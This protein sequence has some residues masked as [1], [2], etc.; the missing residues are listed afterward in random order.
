MDAARALR[1]EANPHLALLYPLEIPFGLVRG[2]P[3]RS[4]VNG[5]RRGR[6]GPYLLIFRPL[7][8]ALM[9]A[10]DFSAISF[11]P[12]LSPAPAMPAS[13]GS[14]Q[15]PI[16]SAAAS[17]HLPSVSRHSLVFGAG[18]ASTPHTASSP[19][20]AAKAHGARGVPDEWQGPPCQDSQGINAIDE[21]GATPLMKA[22]YRRDDAALHELLAH[23]DMDVNARSFSGRTALICAILL[24]SVAGVR[25]L[26]ERP[27]LDVNA[28]E[29]SKDFA[30]MF[31]VTQ[32]NDQVLEMLLADPRVNIR[33]E[34]G[35]GWT[36]LTVARLQR[37]DW[38]VQ[39]LSARE[40][41]LC[42]SQS[43]GAGSRDARRA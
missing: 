4:W 28:Q 31:A 8:F 19:K 37:L 10:P 2:V 30:L 25:A 5:P 16:A 24:E 20:S 11:P 39:L 21:Q 14:G 23:P 26:L 34:D 1:R 9:N 40:L 29:E 32:R 15:P 42:E 3:P 35:N 22:I 17:H 41:A 38:A 12:S 36:A 7:P 13:G 6:T 43:A 33:L 18:V 27:D